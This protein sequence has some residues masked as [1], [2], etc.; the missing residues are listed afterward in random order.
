MVSWAARSKPDAVLVEFIE[1]QICIGGFDA[2]SI[3]NTM[4]LRS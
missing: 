1:H 3:G 2:G 4:R